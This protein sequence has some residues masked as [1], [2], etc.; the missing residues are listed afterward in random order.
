MRRYKTLLALIFVSAGFAYFIFTLLS[1]SAAGKHWRY[2]RMSLP[3]QL[4]LQEQY[5]N[6]PVFLYHLCRKLNAQGQFAAAQPFAERAVGLDPDDAPTRDEWT[7]AMMGTGQATQAYAQLKQYLA[8][9]PKSA[10]AHFLVARYFVTQDKI[11]QAQKLL[12]ETVALDP[13]LHARLG[14]PRPDLHQTGQ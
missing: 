3:E 9:H 13:R 4:R 10:D 7:K 5:V 8:S 14:H 2:A 1:Y 6:D 12:E 11:I